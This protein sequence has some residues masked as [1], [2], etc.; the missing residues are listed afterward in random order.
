MGCCGGGNH[1]MHSQNNK[2]SHENNNNEQVNSMAKMMPLLGI[3]AL[4]LIAVLFI[5]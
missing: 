5:K 2:K 1:N 4:V 3:L